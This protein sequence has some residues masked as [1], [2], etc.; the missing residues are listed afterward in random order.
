MD[1]KTK[2]KSEE[3]REAVMAEAKEAKP[4]HRYIC[5]ACTGNAGV[6]NIPDAVKSITCAV[7]GKTQDC[8]KENWVK[9]K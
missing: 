1:D 6:S 9:I 4:T 8:K 5:D 3:K 7:C 2:S